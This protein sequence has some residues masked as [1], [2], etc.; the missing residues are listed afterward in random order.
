MS[1]PVLLRGATVVDAEG[2]RSA[3]VLVE[4][5]RITRVGDVPGGDN[6]VVPAKLVTPGLIDC[7]VHLVADAGPDLARLVQLSDAQLGA[8]VALNALR[9][10]RGGI[11]TVRDLGGCRHAEFAARD[12]LR[13]LG[14]GPRLLLAGKALTITGGHGWF[15]GRE[16]D[17]AEELVRGAR[18]QV[19]AGADVLKVIA[20]GGVLTTGADPQAAQYTAE[21]LTALVRDAERMGRRVAAHAHGE[22]GIRAAV[23][24]GVASVEHGSYLTEALADRMAT[25]GTFLVPTIAASKSIADAGTE[26]GIPEDSTTSGRSAPG[27]SA[28]WRAARGRAREPVT[29]CDAD[30]RRAYRAGAVAALMRA[31]LAIGIAALLLAGCTTPSSPPPGGDTGSTGGNGGTGN[32]TNPPPPGA[33]ASYTFVA[34][35]YSFSG[36]ASIS[37]GWVTLHLRNDGTE[38]H[39]MGL[40]RIENHTWTEFIT[41]FQQMMGPPPANGTEGNMTGGNASDHHD[42]APPEWVRESGGA[43]GVDPGMTS[44]VTLQLAPGTYAIACFVHGPDGQPHAAHGMVRQLNVTA[45]ASAAT[46][47]LPTP[48]TQVGLIEFNF[49]SQPAAVAAGR[50]VIHV[51][52]KGGAPHMFQILKLK[53]NTTGAELLAMLAGPPPEGMEGPPPFQGWGGVSTLQP[54]MDAYTTVDFSAGRYLYVCFVDDHVAKGMARELTVA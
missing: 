5:G 33:P 45:P 13:Q 51:S 23:E 31:A 38:P 11:T 14:L 26:R 41:L 40:M 27:C 12:M 39:E 18:E 3:D 20:T 10:V 44:T 22:A 36:P 25:Q 50:H 43:G 15:L 52:D 53:G 46:P 32:A 30:H 21:Q 42:E 47:A 8:R 6:E 1:P 54:G 17:S 29:V 7:H 35:E 4:H 28:S 19:R 49:T 16:A 24:A 9:T 2:E 48:D 37:G 34:T